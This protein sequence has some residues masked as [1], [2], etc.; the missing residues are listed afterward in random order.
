MNTIT[1]QANGKRV[2]LTPNGDQIIID[3]SSSRL[4]IEYAKARSAINA[5]FALNVK[6]NEAMARR[7]RRESKTKVVDFL[8]GKVSKNDKGKLIVTFPDQSIAH[9]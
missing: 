1:I 5:D 6:G 8:G 9:L 2:S 7:L 4:S 3:P